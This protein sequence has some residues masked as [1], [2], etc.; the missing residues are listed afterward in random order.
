M[1][2]T[3]SD[4]YRAALEKLKAE[5]ESTPDDRVLGM[6]QESWIDYL[7]KKYGM[8]GIVLDDTRDIVMVEVETEHRLRGYDIYTDRAPGTLVRSTQVRVD[9]PV[10]PSDTIA[11]I[12]KLELSPN[13]FS[14]ATAYPEFEYDHQ[15]GYFSDVV[16][17]EPAAV[18]SG[19]DRI[20]ASVRAYDESIA[21]E[22]RGF[23]PQVVQIVS[24]KRSRLQE[25]HKNL[26]SLAT[27]VGIPLKKKADVATIVPT[28]PKVRSSVVPVLPPVSK[29]QTRP[30]LE[31]DKFA[32]ILSLIDNQCRQ[33]E[34]TPQA[35]QQLSEE[36]LRDI[37]L[38]SLNAVFEGAAGG[39]T[40]Q[41]IGKVDI[42]LRITQGEV[43]VSEIKFWDGP[44]SL[45]EVIKQLRRRLTW[46][47]GYG[48]AIVLSRN[49]GFSEVLKGVADA[50]PTADGYMVASLQ[51][52]DA[53]HWVA[54][55]TIPSDPDRHANINVIVYNLYVVEPARRTVRR[56]K[57]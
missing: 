18:R 55:F 38:S 29:P 53:N 25:K 31:P 17:P 47:D 1:P 10:T 48:V 32:G 15:R 6:D 42:H 49:V 52:R 40:F 35:F 39:E 27:T 43:F 21:S 5:V 9:V 19:V 28:A 44:E 4:Y 12:W 26:D 50:I 30:I 3:I 2:P 57:A 24:S 51:S 45:R 14:L 54:R 11:A 8:E 41:G 23:K 33:F 13:T 20:K 34:R 7:V 37:L 22:N 36:G 16:Q 56:P 46:R